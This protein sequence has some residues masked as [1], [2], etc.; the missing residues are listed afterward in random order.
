MHFS[1]SVF[2][3][4]GSWHFNNL[5]RSRFEHDEAVL[6][7]GRALHGISGRS[8]RVSSFEMSVIDVS[9]GVSLVEPCKL[10]TT[11]ITSKGG[12]A[13][14]QQTPKARLRPPLR[15]HWRHS[16][17]PKTRT[18]ARFCT[19]SWGQ[20]AT[21]REHTPIMHT[22]KTAKVKRVAWWERK[23]RKKLEENSQARRGNGKFIQFYT[24]ILQKISYSHVSKMA[25]DSKR[26]SNDMREE[27]STVPVEAIVATQKALFLN[28]KQ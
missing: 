24:E 26:N 17:P 19:V 25:N 1:V 11:T 15:H 21:W 28:F 12:H 22:V 23:G 13:Q 7:Q 6:A 4:F 2:A 3:S 20:Q 27:R 9:H 18:F 10:Q 16:Q 14:A 5:A 8:P